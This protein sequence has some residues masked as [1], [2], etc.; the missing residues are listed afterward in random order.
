MENKIIIQSKKKWWVY[1][2]ILLSVF[3]M[4]LFV[5]YPEKLLDFIILTGNRRSGSC[6]VLILSVIP[7]SVTVIW[8]MRRVKVYGDRIEVRYPLHKKWN[9]HIMLKDVDCCC[10]EIVEVERKEDY[11]QYKRIYLL[12]GRKL[13]LYISES[14]GSNF[15]EMLSVLTD[16]FGIPIRKGSINLSKEEMKVVRH[17]GYISLD[18]IS[19]EELVAMEKQRKQRRIPQSEFEISRLAKLKYFFIEYGLILSIA[20]IVAFFWGISFVNDY[21]VKQNTVTLSCIDANTEIPSA[22][23]YEVDSVDVESHGILCLDFLI[24]QSHNRLSY[25]AFPIKGRN[26]VWIAVTIEDCQDVK[27]LEAYGSDYCLKVLRK[28]HSYKVVTYEEEY[29]KII[30]EIAKS[31]GVKI[32][33]NFI[34]LHRDGMLRTGRI[35]Y[36]KALDERE[37]SKYAWNDK[38]VFRMMKEAAEEVPAAQYRLGWMYENGLGVAAD[39]AEAIRMYT[40]AAVQECDAMAKVDAMNQ[41]S[42]IYARRHQYR[43]AIEILD[44]AIAFAPMDANLYDSK[45]EHL[46]RSGERDS[47]EMMWKRVLELEPDFL[48]K[49]NSDLYKLLYGK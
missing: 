10:T 25:W 28:S 34:L 35:S 40:Q 6:I 37:R 33:E 3:L 9:Y 12:T 7:I 19:D 41:M 31:S 24:T 43:K 13:W 29:R 15:E 5:L 49:H 38:D 45:G 36:F 26:N 46:Y 1:P 20:V 18:D 42:Y 27:S 39:T 32:D 17:G 22:K 48:E 21:T 2:A 47:A 4:S 16:H 11:D 14:D 23:Y 44:S 30:E 8:F